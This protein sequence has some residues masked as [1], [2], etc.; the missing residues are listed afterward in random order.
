MAMEINSNMGNGA[1]K[2]FGMQMGKVGM[3]SF[4]KNIQSQIA[5]KQKEM[6]ELSK[7][8]D[9]SLEDK[10]K[11]RQEIQQEIADLNNQLRQHQ[12]EQRK[13]QQTKKLGTDDDMLG[14]SNHA[15][16][17]E[18]KSGTGMSSASMQAIISADA[19]MGQVKVQS[20]V[21]TEMKGKAAVLKSEIQMDK[22]R[23]A[24]TEAKEAELADT[25]EKIDNITSTQM[26]ALSDINEKLEEAEKEDHRD[27]K[28]DEKKDKKEVNQNDSHKNGEADA[29]KTVAES[30]TPSNQ[31]AT[32]VDV[33]L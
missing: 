8:E 19:S 27:E 14:G 10:I 33:R 24:S 4:S 29:L 3:D 23:G 31:T 17:K 9:M 20:S 15:P 21:K 25:E 12:I 13:E 18:E 7:S 32:Y 30:T 28:T 26:S 6:Q 22:G 16:K 1:I 2:G 11:K 5:N